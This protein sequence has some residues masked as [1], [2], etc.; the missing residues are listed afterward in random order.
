MSSPH[1]TTAD[2]P[3][4]RL[5]SG[6]PFGIEAQEAQGGREM[7]N[8]STLPAVVRPG[9]AEFETLGFA[10]G[11]PV[12]G[13]DLFV[14]ATLPEGWKR[15]AHTALWTYIVDERGIQRVAMF[16]KA[17]FYD[18]HAHMSLVD[19]GA[20]VA[21]QYIF[22]D[23]ALFEPPVTLTDDER[24]EAVKAARHYVESPYRDSLVE[25]AQVVLDHFDAG[26]TR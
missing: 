6:H 9:R 17:A 1:N 19:V 3:L 13:D 12:E 8:A 26:A 24:A 23:E 22:G 20:E 21:S 5:M 18:R 4:E 2:S 11:E 15:Q 25:R 10:F 16:Y 7:A 14:H